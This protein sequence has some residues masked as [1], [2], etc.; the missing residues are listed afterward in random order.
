MLKPPKLKLTPPKPYE[1]LLGTEGNSWRPGVISLVDSTRIPKGAVSQ[2][3][4][5][6]QTQDGIWS[7]RWGSANYGQPLTGPTTGII[8]YTVTSG[9]VTEQWIMVMDAGKLKIS[10]DGGTWTTVASYTFST[11]N[12]TCFV[13]YENKILI[14]NGIDPFS[15]FDLGTGTLIQFTPL[16][17]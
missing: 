10:K 1:D 6:M 7:T 16:S 12:T 11:A 8:Q 14:A 9:G 2:A 15:Y 5:C 13:Y 3:K 17:V 4:N